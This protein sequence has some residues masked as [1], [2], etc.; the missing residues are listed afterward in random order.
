MTDDV[1]PDFKIPRTRCPEHL[2][3]LRTLPCAIPGCHHTPSQPHHLTCAP[4]PKARG[5]KAGDVWAV[6]LCWRHHDARSGQ[7]VHY[8]GDERSWWAAYHL[9][10]IVIATGLADRSR[11]LGILP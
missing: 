7:S 3:W 8:R 5:M 10:P 1:T 6:P 9:D 2:E 11:R 4:E